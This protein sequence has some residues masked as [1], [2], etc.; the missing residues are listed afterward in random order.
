M[1]SNL[2]PEKLKAMYQRTGAPIHVSYALSQLLAFYGNENNQDIAKRIHSWQTISSICSYRWR[3]RRKGIQMPISFS[4]ASWTGMLNF[5]TCTWDDDT[6]QLLATSTS[7]EGDI[8]NA[9]PPLVDYD[10]TLPFLSK[11]I[12][13]YNG[14]GSVNHYWEKWPELRT[15]ELRFFLGLGDGAAANVG[16]KCGCLSLSDKNERQ[17][18]AV[19]IGTSAAA[20]V[21]LPLPVVSS[22]DEIESTISI[23]PGLFCYRVNKSTILV[24]GALTDGGSVIEWA[25]SLF[26]L[27]STESFDACIHEVTA[28]YDKR[29]CVPSSSSSLSSGNVTMIPFLTGERSTGYR[30]G[31]RGCISSISRETT[32]NDIMYAC[33][34]SVVLRLVCVL[35]LIENVCSSRQVEESKPQQ[36]VI[37][38]SGSALECS[39]LWRQMLADC[40]LMDVVVDSDSSE[41]TSRGVAMLLATSLHQNELGKSEQLVIKS[42]TKTNSVA[43]EY[44][45]NALATQES[46]VQAVFGPTLFDKA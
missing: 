10:A 4:E 25:R 19:T 11:G 36:T 33:L 38:A 27:Q 30:S 23:P 22:H 13:Q 44:W 8:S 43:N 7:F 37:V 21:C 45:R 1:C 29:C 46:L 26:N 17:R 5:R 42:E 18:I 14:D 20:R 2:G 32:A 12:P 39:T 9:L 6:I 34:E 24:G 15:N 3:G 31:A 41:G 35:Q 28:M 40:S 16:S